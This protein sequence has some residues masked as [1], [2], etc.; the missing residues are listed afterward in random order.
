MKNI[1]CTMQVTLCH[2][3]KTCSAIT[4][5]TEIGARY[6]ILRYVQYKMENFFGLLH[7]KSFNYTIVSQITLVFVLIFTNSFKE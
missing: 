2:V 1:E 7:N 3:P 4:V 5:E 6:K